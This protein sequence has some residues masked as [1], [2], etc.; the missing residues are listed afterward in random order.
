MYLPL[1]KRLAMTLGS[2]KTFN[3]LLLVDSKAELLKVSFFFP[4]PFICMR[5]CITKKVFA[6]ILEKKKIF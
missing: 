5:N 2:L 3:R 4:P 6:E 1:I